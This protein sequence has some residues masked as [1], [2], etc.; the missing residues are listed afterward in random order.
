[1]WERCPADDGGPAWR[2]ETLVNGWDLATQPTGCR[3]V[4]IYTLRTITRSDGSRYQKQQFS[5]DCDD[6]HGTDPQFTRWRTRLVP[7]S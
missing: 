7:A 1:M 4:D 6:P 5:G 2:Y 3:V